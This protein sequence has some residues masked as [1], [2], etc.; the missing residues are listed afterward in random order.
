MPPLAELAEAHHGAARQ[1]GLVSNSESAPP[2]SVCGRRPD[3]DD[4]GE[5]AQTDF[6]RS[7]CAGSSTFGS[8]ARLQAATFI[9]GFHFLSHLFP[10]VGRFTA[11][12][13]L[14]QRSLGSFIPQPD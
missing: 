1:S 9:I 11:A 10:A 6:C 7:R 4:W 12:V 13:T 14:D 8:V 5:G 2:N 3:L